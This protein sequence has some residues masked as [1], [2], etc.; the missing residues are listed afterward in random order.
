MIA[1]ATEPGT[2]RQV[3]QRRPGGM[4]P[5]RHLHWI[6]DEL[7]TGGWY[8]RVR[9]SG[10]AAIFSPKNANSRRVDPHGH[11]HSLG[12]LDPHAQR[13]LQPRRWRQDR[14]PPLSRM[15]F[16][17]ITEDMGPFRR[18][19]SCDVSKKAREIWPAQK[20][21]PNCMVAIFL[22]TVQSDGFIAPGS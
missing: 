4:H 20:G 18:K 9:E 10:S 5:R 12:H 2:P 8:F 13:P 11:V 14:T 22:V 15:R 7:P 1:R 16:A 6:R 21:A 17:G 19:C 3:V